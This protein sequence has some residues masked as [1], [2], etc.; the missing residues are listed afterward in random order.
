MELSHPKV[1]LSNTILGTFSLTYY[2]RQFLGELAKEHTNKLDFKSNEWQWSHG[3]FYLDNNLNKLLDKCRGKTREEVGYVVANLLRIWQQIRGSLDGIDLSGIDLYDFNFS[4]FQFGTFR[5]RSNLSRSTI[6]RDSL[7]FDTESNLVSG[8]NFDAIDSNL[9]V[10][11]PDGSVAFWSLAQEKRLYQLTAFGGSYQQNKIIF[12]KAGDKILLI[13]ENGPGEIW[14]YTQRKL[15]HSI[16][17]QREQSATFITGGFNHAGTQVALVTIDRQIVIW[18][19]AAK[20]VLKELSK[21]HLKPIVKV[22]FSKDDKKLITASKDNTI[23][24]TTIETDTIFKVLEEHKNAIHDIHL[25]EDGTKILSASADGTV[26]IW[27][28]KTGNFLTNLVD[29]VNDSSAEVLCSAFLLADNRKVISI[30]KDNTARI[31]DVETETIDTSI[32]LEG[33]QDKIISAAISK[34]KKLVATSFDDMTAKVW[35]LDTGKDLLTVGKRRAWYSDIKISL[36]EQ[37]LALSSW[38]G[39]IQLWDVIEQKCIAKLQA[40][41]SLV[42]GVYLSRSN[43]Y[44]ITASK[45]GESKIW[46]LRTLQDELIETKLDKVKHICVNDTETTLLIS[47]ERDNQS[48]I[49][50]NSVTKDKDYWHIRNEYEL[51]VDGY[52]TPCIT[53]LL[54]KSLFAVSSLS[55]NS[56]GLI[57]VYDSATGH[58]KIEVPAHSNPITGLSADQNGHYLLSN[59][60]D[61]NTILWNTADW[62]IIKE[63]VNTEPQ[64]SCIAIDKQ[65][66]LAALGFKNGRIHIWNRETAANL[67]E[68]KAFD[69]R[70]QKMFF[71]KQSSTIL[72]ISNIGEIVNYKIPSLDKDLV[73]RNMPELFVNGCSFED[74]TFIPD[75]SVAERP[76]LKAHGGIFNEQDEAAWQQLNAKWFGA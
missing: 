75:L 26:K 44:L 31:W 55:K 13:N 7:F 20:K 9:V 32:R 38:S 40:H 27:D 73:I 30:S 23:V 54:Q 48:L 36:N 53:F 68:F 28:S 39:R 52:L 72:A 62:T 8:V 12:N 66:K 56:Q 74:S 21:K 1:A 5:M 10:A 76:V 11:S 22:I 67:V 49:R 29:T 4:K 33:H 16:P 46:N 6:D 35:S 58:L 60:L 2:V 51:N 71:L 19:I 25:S 70:V 3:A 15:F 14:D 45:N 34:N 47:G 61:N 18:N 41:S 17:A 65:G 64:V 59:S 50:V 69:T 42:S 37:L 43:K 63:F 57:N 24:I